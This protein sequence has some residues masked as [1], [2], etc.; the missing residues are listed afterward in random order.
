MGQEL[1]QVGAKLRA[2]RETKGMSQGT[3]AKKAGAAREH[4]LRLEDGRHDP[5]VSTLIR[6]AKAVAV[7]VTE[8]LK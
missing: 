8:L 3:L 4:L 5:A 1:K 7:P 2:T 6:I